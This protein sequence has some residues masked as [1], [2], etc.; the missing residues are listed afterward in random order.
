MQRSQNIPFLSFWNSHV[1]P[2]R[3]CGIMRSEHHPVDVTSDSSCYGGRLALHFHYVVHPCLSDSSERKLLLAALLSLPSSLCI[4][5]LP[6]QSVECFGTNDTTAPVMLATW[7]FKILQP[8]AQRRLSL[9]P[10]RMNSLPVYQI[11]MLYRL[12]C[13]EA[14]AMA[15]AGADKGLSNWE[16]HCNGGRRLICPMQGLLLLL[17]LALCWDAAH[18]CSTLLM[19]ID[20]RH[21]CTLPCNSCC[22]IHA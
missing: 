16:Y 3:A 7:S 8:C 6:G 12:C 18:A 20:Q 17:W 4:N 5:L 11:M 21:V 1:G 15:L 14:M 9:M 22:P 19:V 13:R 10:A 2:D